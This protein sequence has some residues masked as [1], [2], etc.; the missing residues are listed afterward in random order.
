METVSIKLES[1]IVK[2]IERLMKEC[3]YVTKTEFIR[4]AI[5]D[6]LEQLENKRAYARVEAMY[7]ASKRKTTDADLK[8][9]RERAAQELIKE[10]DA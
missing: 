9:A 3:H 7:G 6:K 2:S 4:D 10:L 1:T 5:R 8:R